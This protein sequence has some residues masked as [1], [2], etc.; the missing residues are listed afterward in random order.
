MTS[1]EK[2]K[3]KT[4]RDTETSK[5]SIF[6]YVKENNIEIIVAALLLSGKLRFDAV[7][8]FREATLIISLVGK[9]ETLVDL[10]NK[11]IDRMVKLFKDNG[12]KTINE[13]IKE[14]YTS[15]NK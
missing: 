10:N 4:T 14:F 3:G 11:D 8:L 2:K 15:S 7:Q 5:S 1:H 6:D 12:D 9:Y 13:I